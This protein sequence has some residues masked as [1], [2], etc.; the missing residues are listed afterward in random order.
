MSTFE[1]SINE[2]LDILYID[3]YGLCKIE[4]KKIEFI[5]L[6]NK[7]KI[8]FTPNEINQIIFE[9]NRVYHFSKL[10]KE[11]SSLIFDKGKSSVTKFDGIM[12]KN[13]TNIF[14]KSELYSFSGKLVKKDKVQYLFIT[15]DLNEIIKLQNISQETKFLE[16]NQYV[17][18]L[19]VTFFEKEEGVIVLNWEKFSYVNVLDEY[20]K[21][22]KINQKI[23][24][25]FNLFDINEGNNQVL[26]PKFGIEISENQII[27][28]DSNKDTIF[29]I[30]EA[31]NRKEEYFP[32]KIYLYNKKGECIFKKLKGKQ[33]LFFAYKGFLTE[34]NI[35]VKQ[36]MG[37]VYEFI[38]FS[39][40]D[41]LPK[42]IYIKY[43]PEKTSK[44]NNFHNFN[45]KNRKR[46]IFVNV[47]FQD[48]AD[49]EYD[50]SFLNIYL[51]S[52]GQQKLYASFLISSINFQLKKKYSYKNV[53]ISNIINIY[54]DY[55]N[56]INYKKNL[57]NSN[58]NNNKDKEN[59]NENNYNLKKYFSFEEKIN[60]DLE[61]ELLNEKFYLY[62]FEDNEFTLKYF[63]ALCFWYFLY[64]INKN[65][66]SYSKIDD[67][68][69]LYI[70]LIKKQG[71]SYIEKSMILVCIIDRTF[72]NKNSLKCPKL[73]FYDELEGK[74]NPYIKAYKFELELINNLKEESC[75][76]QSLLLLD[77]YIMKCMKP[78]KILLDSESIMGYSISMLPLE[79][80]KEHLKKKIKNYFLVIKKEDI[81]SPREY[82]S[83]VHKNIGMITYNEHIL[84]R[85]SNCDSMYD[86]N[87]NIFPLQGT[88]CEDYSFLIHLENLRENFG[89]NKEIILNYGYS[90]ILYFNRELKHA[91]IYNESN[92]E[93]DEEGCLIV[94]FILEDKKLLSEIKNNLYHVGDYLKLEYFI[95]KNFDEIKK[96]LAVAKKTYDDSHKNESKNIIPDEE[97]QI[98]GA[99]KISN[100]ENIIESKESD[101]DDSDDENKIILSEYNTYILS[102]ESFEELMDKVEGLKGKKIIR[103]KRNITNDKDNQYY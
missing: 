46:I 52:K 80:I 98:K 72:E 90:P 13:N 39:I 103:R 16:E 47:E 37:Y 89:Y 77:S 66:R 68:N 64:Y 9:N 28:F 99:K 10:K 8:I 78:K 12:I 48:E 53:V 27:K 85:N 36:I 51:C 29:Y 93:N 95:D 1:N 42:E 44:F 60:K 40:D 34:L 49:F 74:R 3:F 92:K 26:I 22:E 50:N 21:D 97:T 101:D 67:Y 69:K 35:F 91:Y 84:L 32:Q 30:Y 79:I 25:Q 55:M 56:Y 61:N 59:N 15:S 19:N 54:E 62:E 63:N 5:G 71:L 75:L 81:S 23:A 102:A 57:K 43:N 45:S 6:F 100:T 41:S 2:N 73:L 18:I 33:G 94:S 96:K 86:V 14:A 11:K 58:E 7:E 88:V 70:Q 31:R 83:N 82:Y 65:N 4:N 87:E 20:C 17:Q 38:Y 24:L 76:F